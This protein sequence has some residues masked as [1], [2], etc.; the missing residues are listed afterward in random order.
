MKVYVISIFR[1]GEFWGNP[2]VFLDEAKA[3]KYCN[4]VNKTESYH[5]FY[6]TRIAK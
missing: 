5:A 1:W 4:R 6:C 2:H 3:E